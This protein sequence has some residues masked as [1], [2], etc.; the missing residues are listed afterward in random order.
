MPKLKT[1]SGHYD[2]AFS[3]THNNRNFIPKNVDI[4]RIPWNYNCVS[5]GEEA[6]F[7]SDDPRHISEFWQRYQELNEMYWQNRSLAQTLAYKRYHEHLEYMR[8]YCHPFFRIPNNGI[9]ALVTLLL[10][11]LFVPCGIYL[12]HHQQQA[13]KEWEQFKEEQWLQD[14]YFKASRAS[15]RNALYTHDHVTGTHYLRSM[16]Q[17][18]TQLAA[19][20]QNYEVIPPPVQSESSSTPRFASLEEIY[21]KLYEPSFRKFQAKQRPCRRY[22]GTY[23]EQIREGQR[24]Q[25]QKKQQSKNANSRKTSE[26]I[27]IVFGIGDMDNTGY[28]QAPEDAKKAEVLLKDFCDHLMRN[29]KLCCITTKE[30]NDPNWIPPFNNGLIVLNLTV[31]ADE[32]TPGIHLTCIPYSRNCKRGPDVQA[33]L[34]KAMAGMGYPSTWKDKLDDQEKKIPK[35]DRN[36]NIVHNQDGSTRYQQE[37]DGQGIIDW[38]EDQKQWIQ[39]EMEKRYDWDRE[40]K[41]SHARGN[42]ST[43]DYQVARA[44]ERNEV[45]QH[46]LD[47]SL[48]EYNDA[49]YTLTLKLD[50]AVDQQWQEASN[51]DIIERYLSVC[52]DAEYDA[53]LKNA[54]AYLDQLA[55]TEQ[56]RCR[57]KLI[58]KIQEAE[59]K[60]SDGKTKDH[61]HNKITR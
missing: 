9:E 53:I 31:H 57:N 8:K 2:T 42:L 38:I 36:G 52:T 47:E 59:K 5:V 27:E 45:Y 33:S 21:E 17:T 35:R 3:I 37:P 7:E 23:L 4:H 48:Q 16:D 46:L 56:D 29:P 34:G 54:S 32:A 18:V 1:I 30:L 24:A 20:A 12:T 11:P 28:V 60:L 50:D 40:Y 26:A 6:Y 58:A 43:P 61:H 14:M 19:I 15:L 51:Q 55:Y 10:L 41:G 39:K 44:K 22:N 13:K 25:T 49:V